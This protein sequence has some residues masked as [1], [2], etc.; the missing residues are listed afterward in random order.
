MQSMGEE[1]MKATS[2]Q[3]TPQWKVCDL[4]FCLFSFPIG[5]N[6]D[7]AICGLGQKKKRRRRRGRGRSKKRKKKHPQNG[8]ATMQKE[9]GRLTDVHSRDIV[10]SSTFM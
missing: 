10:P 6:I 5:W 3:C 2:K 7:E 1:V 4:S 8:G 9:P